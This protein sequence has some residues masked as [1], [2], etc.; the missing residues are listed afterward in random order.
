MEVDWHKYFPPT[1]AVKK[2]KSKFEVLREPVPLGPNFEENTAIV[3]EWIWRCGR[4]AASNEFPGSLLVHMRDRWYMVDQIRFESIYFHVCDA[5]K[6]LMFYTRYDGCWERYLEHRESPHLHHMIQDSEAAC[7]D[8]LWGAF[9]CTGQNDYFWAIDHLN[10]LTI[11][12][13]GYPEPVKKM[14]ANDTL[15]FFSCSKCQTAIPKPIVITNRLKRS[16][17]V[18]IGY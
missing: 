7:R 14:K 2:V 18:D 9:N 8:A 12:N 3:L 6:M 13:V 4:Y 10:E 5:K 17:L 16:K 11:D 15:E 1:T